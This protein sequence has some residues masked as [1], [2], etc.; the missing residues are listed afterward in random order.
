MDFIETYAPVGKLTI[1]RYLISL[2]GKYDWNIDQLDVGTAFFNPEV[3]EEDI[4]MT[5]PEGWPEGLNAPM[6]IVP[7]QKALYSLKLAPRLEYNDINT[8]LLFLEFTH[9]QGNPY[10]HLRSNGILTLLYIDD[11]SVMYPQD[12]TK[13]VIEA[14]ARLL[15]KYK[16]TNLT[17]A[18]QILGIEI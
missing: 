4:Y 6:M 10:L 16:I 17:P 11:I 1:F 14:K 3:D 9:S 13:A 2:V 5:L 8:F 7:I 12:A 15:E 18:P